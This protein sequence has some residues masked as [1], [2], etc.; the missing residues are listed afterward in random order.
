[1][2]I[3]KRALK[4]RNKIKYLL[5]LAFLSV[6]ISTLPSLTNANELTIY[7]TPSEFTLAP[8]E[9]AE[10]S[11]T[12]TNTSEEKSL[13]LRVFSELY[14]IEEDKIISD[15]ENEPF[16]TSKSEK[17]TVE[18]DTEKKLD[19]IVEV[20]RGQQNGTYYNILYLIEANEIEQE[21][22]L[23][24]K[25]GVGYIVTINVGTEGDIK[26]AYT[27]NTVGKLTQFSRGFPYLLP[28]EALYRFENGSSYT[29]IPDGEIRAFD[30]KT[31]ELLGYTKINP[32]E[33]KI[34]PGSGYEQLYKLENNWELSN[35]FNDIRIVH[36]TYSQHGDFYIEHSI[37]AR[38]Y[39]SEILASVAIITVI[40]VGLV[41]YRR[42][43]KNKFPSK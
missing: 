9:K 30:N 23:A 33:L 35:I 8:S 38:S 10:D 32:D 36:R 34:H 29:F 12:V 4:A 26:G 21:E 20:P 22:S 25:K 3:I 41:I 31:N 19:F 24:F 17:I 16:V 2:R 39:K 27:K 40:I 18:A 7:T 15:S 14:D 13:E 11:I 6:L 43:S 5:A 42:N 28:T 1:M 37:T